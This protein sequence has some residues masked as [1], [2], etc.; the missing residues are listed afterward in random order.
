MPQFYYFNFDDERLLDFEV[1]DFQNLMLAFGKTKTAKTIFLDEIQN[2]PNWERF[3]RRIHDE[4]YK[5]FLTG[6]KA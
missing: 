3:V 4:G 5:V 6:S 1:S 2:V